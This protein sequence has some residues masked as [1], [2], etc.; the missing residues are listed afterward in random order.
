MVCCSSQTYSGI[1]AAGHCGGAIS[2]AAAEAKME[3]REKLIAQA[4]NGRAETAKGGF[5]GD[6]GS[7]LSKIGF[8]YGGEQAKGRR[9]FPLELQARPPRSFWS[10][11]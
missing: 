8:R 3:V 11:A 7:G 4:H 9:H 10:T 2:F 1:V 6:G 5:D